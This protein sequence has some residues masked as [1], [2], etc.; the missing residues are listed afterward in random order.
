MNHHHST[1]HPGVERRRF[2]RKSLSRNMLIWFLTLSLIPLTVMSTISYRNA[3]QSLQRLSQDV[4]V[5]MADSSTAQIHY[6]FDHM[7]LNLKQESEEQ[8][9]VRL[10]EM[11]I[12]NFKQSRLSPSEFVDSYRWAQIVEEHGSDLRTF[13]FT[14]QLKDVLLTDSDGH[15]LFTVVGTDDLGINLFTGPLSDTCLSRAVKRTFDSGMPTFSDFMHYPP[16][17]DE[18][19]GFLTSI[20][21]NDSGQKIGAIILNIDNRKIDAIIQQS[22][23]QGLTGHAYLIGEDLLLRSNW[24]AMGPGSVLTQKIDTPQTNLW[25]DWHV[26]APKPTHAH[27]DTH[28]ASIYMGPNHREVLGIHRD[29]EIAGTHWAV[30]A[31]RETA[32]A[33]AAAD[34]L[35]LFMFGLLIGTGLLV[36]FISIPLMKR[37]FRPLQTLS[38]ATRRISGGDLDQR[39]SIQSDNEIGELA[40]N[41]NQMV[42]SL[43]HA[44]RKTE[45]ENWFKNGLAEISD[46]M[47]GDSNVAELSKKV[48]TFLSKYLDAKVGAV[49]SAVEN[50]HLQLTGSYAF[51]KRKGLS[52]S[53]KI[54]EGLVGQ[55]ALE[56]ETIQLTQ[57]PAD[58]MTIG[59]GLGETPP[60]AI[61][62][63]P[64]I[65]ENRVEGVAELGFLEAPTDQKRDFLLQAAEPI[66]LSFRVAR[67]RKKM[68]ALLEKTQIQ[69]EE[70]RV[71]EEELRENNTLL[72]KQSRDLKTSE[73]SLMK[74]QVDLEEKNQTL[75]QQQNELSETNDQ[76]QKTAAELEQQT[77]TLEIQKTEIEEKN[78]ELEK[79]RTDLERKA[80]ELEIT[81]KYKSEFLA[82]MSHELRTPLNSLLILSKLLSNNEDDNL[83]DKQVQFAQTI[84]DS[85]NDLL[86]LINE[87]LDLSKIEAGRM[88]IDVEALELTDLIS[89]IHKKFD[90]LAEQKGVSFTAGL[91]NIGPTRMVT[92][93]Q[94]LHQ[95]L[96]NLLSNAFKF[97][98]QGAITLSIH[99]IPADV[100]FFRSELSTDQAICFEV[101]DTGVGIDT[102]K[103]K[104]IFEAFQQEDGSTSR[105]Y[106]G[107]GLGLSISREL[108]KLLGGEIHIQ[109]QK[110]KGSR[111]SLYL[112]L[113]IH[114]SGNLAAPGHPVSA[115]PT[116]ETKPV[117]PAVVEPAAPPAPEN[118]KSPAPDI[119]DVRDDRRH[120][121]AGDRSIL[122]I[123]D[124]PKFANILMEFA[125]ERD[126]KCLIAGD[127]ETG[128]HFAEYYAPSGI[129][130][131]IGL[132]KMDG[133]GVMDRL[134]ENMKTRH[135][136]VHF[137][138]AADN[139][140]DALMRGAVGYLT[141]PAKLDDINDVFGKL[142]TIISKVQKELLVVEDDAI[143]AESIKALVGN[144][145]VVT[146]VAASA[147]E[148]VALLE[149]HRFDCIVL[150]LGLPDM[151]GQAFLEHLRKSNPRDHIP[152][153]VYTGKEISDEDHALLSK[154]ADS[155]LVKGARSPER[156]LDE[157]ALF[158]HRVESKLPRE[159]R[160]MIRMLHDQE[161]VLKDKTVLLVDDD[162]RNVYALSQILQDKGIHVLTGKDGK[163]G[164]TKLLA[165]PETDLVLMDI[166]MPEMDGYEAMREIRKNDTYSQLPIIAL[167]A[168]AMKGDRAKCMAAG[169]SDYLAKPV[170]PSKLLSMLRVWMYR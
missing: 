128:L 145:D 82:N 3:R 76:L 138:S 122:I 166:M 25:R 118:I 43:K 144:G 121:H 20:L 115:R 125:R 74:Q 169:A 16:M 98:D 120:I 32:V 24:D 94:K 95:I 137:I 161:A 6:Y 33:F 85:G 124:D 100:S 148:A 151:T 132:P 62:V 89:D 90:T 142:E 87:I 150:D 2:W 59:S 63:V 106:G 152:V 58:Y 28:N 36:V 68:K 1:S 53:F 160:R 112:P 49:Y 23:G 30:V 108:A 143:Q 64:L 107:T 163:Q 39:I 93:I 57:I 11:L 38:L 34:R 135:I 70:L 81:G 4:L 42:T 21:V 79:I 80:A 55:A 29:F 154:Y 27:A 109:S 73:D 162:M 158:L 146:T 69:A 91:D 67:N 139:E 123:E 15:V 10:L 155:I 26:D 88:S 8:S 31:E 141:K 133:W 165:H 52:N 45:L 147:S 130:L 131:D 126:F 136:P 72:E 103:Q 117:P 156:L 75:E 84:Y 168:K 114:D 116:L 41:F 83:T 92:D 99:S 17:N 101:T 78:N 134:K 19:S 60:C 170:D 102:A 86:N 5:S 149:D 40:N 47:R 46:H 111:F 71:R 104:L 129:I 13:C 157:T 119:D 66:A 12:D 35:K 9:N 97:T 51:H 7:F 113:K 50:D 18:I 127:G 110:N 14:F 96:N 65:N 105:K 44:T 48:I 56:K 37:T 61:M 54:G 164:I 159:K 140:F 77:A 22:T 167:T 153:I